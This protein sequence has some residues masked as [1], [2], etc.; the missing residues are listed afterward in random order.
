MNTQD[1]YLENSTVN[2]VSGFSVSISEY[3]HRP[4]SIQW[5]VDVRAN[6]GLG[7]AIALS[8]SS[9]K[10]KAVQDVIDNLR[11]QMNA[12]EAVIDH[13]ERINA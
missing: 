13:L 11:D 5:K 1:Y 10:H 9:Q 3:P 2:N 6:D 12:I 7:D 8:C 4:A